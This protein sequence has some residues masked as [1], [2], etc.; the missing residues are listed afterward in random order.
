VEQFTDVT[1]HKN[2][3]LIFRDFAPKPVC[4]SSK[5]LAEKSR[6]KPKVGTTVAAGAAVLHN[7]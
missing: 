6:Q 7:S 2:T 5:L 4:R 1:G 3:K